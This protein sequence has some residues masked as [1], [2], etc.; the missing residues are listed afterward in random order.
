MTLALIVWLV[1]AAIPALKSLGI[2]MFL[3]CCLLL[4]GGLIAYTMPGSTENDKK[5][6]RWT[7]RNLKWAIPV[8][9]IISMLPAEKTS[10]YM[11]GAYGTQKI[12][13][14]PIAQ[15]LAGDG[16]DVLKSLM[17]RAKAEIEEKPK[18]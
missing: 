17:A 16:V 11:V 18:K 9:I 12:V 7:L 1:M 14:S 10:W 5:P 2:M 6:M 13:E 3:T 15:E 4:L 8:M